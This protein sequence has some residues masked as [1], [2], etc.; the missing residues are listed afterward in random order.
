M[1]PDHILWFFILIKLLSKYFIYFSVIMPHFYHVRVNVIYISSFKVMKK[2]SNKLFIKKYKLLNFLF[3]KEN[4][5]TIEISKQWA[6][7]IFFLR[8][9]WKYTRPSKPNKIFKSCF[10]QSINSWINL[11]SWFFE[12][13]CSILFPINCKWQFK[14][15]H[16]H[17]ILIS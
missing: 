11:A 15:E 16:D 5:M 6:N 9:F 17:T 7:K 8:I 10:I 12:K 14:T 4:R 3:L 1:D 13:K 2:W